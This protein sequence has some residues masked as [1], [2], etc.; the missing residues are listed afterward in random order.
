MIN[1][2]SV[3]RLAEYLLLD[4]FDTSNN[5]AIMKIAPIPVTAVIISS[6]KITDIV[7]AISISV[8]SSIVDVEA[9]I[10]FSPFSHK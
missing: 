4:C 7:V 3:L 2:F 8:R 10:C 1:P 9:E 5:A 6:S